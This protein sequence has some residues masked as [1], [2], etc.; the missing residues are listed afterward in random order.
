M[1]K[2]TIQDID[3]IR[4]KSGLSYNEAV[5]LLKYHN[6]SLTQALL[7]LEKNGKILEHDTKTNGNGRNR[8]RNIFYLLYRFRLKIRKDNIVILNLSALFLIFA[9]LFAPWV[10]I[11]GILFALVMGYHIRVDRISKEFEDVS[12]EDTIKHAGENIKHTVDSIIRESAKDDQEDEPKESE[13][14]EPRAQSPASGT[15]PV[16]VELPEESE[17]TVKDDDD[18]YHEASVG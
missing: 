18:G 8:H 2:Y 3:I 13:V 17:F 15:K 12:F 16:D 14:K 4:R 6:G 11:V 9:L 10:V 1:A 5:S 7:D